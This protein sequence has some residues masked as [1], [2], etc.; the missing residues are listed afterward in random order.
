MPAAYCSGCGR[1]VPAGCDGVACRRPLD[2]PRFCPTCRRRLTVLI[3]PTKVEARC[4]E[5]GEVQQS[6]PVGPDA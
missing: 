2:P 3:T 1:P 5:H 4:R 6:G